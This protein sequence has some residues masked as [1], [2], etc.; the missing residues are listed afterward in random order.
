MNF[1]RCRVCGDE[2]PTI[3]WGEL[4]DGLGNRLEGRAICHCCGN[5]SSRVIYASHPEGGQ[6]A[7]VDEIV[8]TWNR[9]N[10]VVMGGVQEARNGQRR[11]S[12][13]CVTAAFDKR[14]K[15]GVRDAEV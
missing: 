11:F 8:K 14:D 3:R 13:G 1:H 5:I 7:V 6:P 12:G 2:R 4:V 9:E 15:W 10:P